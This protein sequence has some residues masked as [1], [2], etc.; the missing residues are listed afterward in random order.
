MITSPEWYINA[1]DSETLGP[2]TPEQMIEFANDGS[3][4]PNT[5]V[6]NNTL[7]EWIT[8]GQVDGLFSSPAHAVQEPSMPSQAHEAAL[9]DPSAPAWYQNPSGTSSDP[10]RPRPKSTI[11]FLESFSKEVRS[12]PEFEAV[13]PTRRIGI[14]AF[15]ARGADAFRL[16]LKEKEIHVFGLL[17]AVAIGIA[18]LLWVQALDWFP[19]EAWNEDREGP[20]VWD[21]LF[22]VWSILCIGFAAFFLGVFS[23]CMGAVHFL[24]AQGEESTIARCLKI[25]MPNA[26]RLWAFHWVDGF[27]TC[28]R[29]LE[30]LPKKENKPSPAARALSEALYYAWKVGSIGFLPSLILGNSLIGAGKDSLSLVKSRFKDVALLRAGYSA[31]SWVIGILTYLGGAYFIVQSGF[32]DL[33]STES[34]GRQIF[35]FFLAAGIPILISVALIQMFI[36]PLFIISLCEIYSEFA[37]ERGD[38]VELPEAPKKG[39]AALVTFLAFLLVLTLAGFY[40]KSF[41]TA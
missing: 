34:T 4:A 30:R 29:I 7:A 13:R 6:W 31:I 10:K 36:R 18:Y 41:L 23:G 33:E 3:I 14:R 37:R 32:V 16:S 2:Y 8:A 40:L 5:Q 1:P 9:G 38:A 15:F 12:L 19:E 39:T 11:E 24:H 25:V 21:I 27:I 35:R 22:L 17:Q 28:H 20:S 26:L